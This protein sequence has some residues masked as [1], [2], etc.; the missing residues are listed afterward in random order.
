M[1]AEALR[2]GGA[3]ELTRF[4]R[5]HGAATLA[6]AIRLGVPGDDP[7]RV[8]QRALTRSVRR[9]R[10]FDGAAPIEA[11]V[12]WNLAVVLR[13]AR[14]R[15]ALRR[16]L[17]QR[18]DRSARPIGRSALLLRRRERVVAALATLPRAQREAAVLIDLEG[19]TAEAAAVLLRRRSEVVMADLAAARPTIDHMMTELGLSPT[20][21]GDRGA[22]VLEMPRRPGPGS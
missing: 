17:P 13:R 2:Q 15:S 22:R 1:A 5:D 18:R 7:A 19:R 16:L 21:P 11:W 9:I 10:R 6:W 14:W 8:A 12:F 4:Y 20:D 3:D